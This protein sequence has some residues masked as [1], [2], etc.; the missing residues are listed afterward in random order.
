M[1]GRGESIRACFGPLRREVTKVQSRLSCQRQGSSKGYLSTSQ[2]ILHW[3]LVIQNLLFQPS[4]RQQS[5]G[6]PGKE[7][8]QAGAQTWSQGQGP[9]K[10]DR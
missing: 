7:P 2:G 6:P 10:G 1:K 5:Q 3:L 4:V 8:T 9:S